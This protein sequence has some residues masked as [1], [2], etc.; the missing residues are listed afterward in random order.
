MLLPRT[1]FLVGFL[2]LVGTLRAEPPLHQ[3]IDALVVAGLPNYAEAAAPRCDD[4]EFL[5][6]VSLDL[7]GTIPPAGEVR[8]FLNDAAP[9]KRTKLVDRLLDS[10]EHARHFATVID[11][12]LME[13]RA[14][15]NVASADW[16]DYLRESVAANKPW[17]ALVREILSSDGADPKT[18][19]SGRFL[20]DRAGEPHLITRDIGRL[21]LGVNLQCAQCH[22]H[23]RVED[24]KQAHYYGI[25]A[26][27]GRTGLV[28]DP[29]LKLAVLTEKADGEATFQSVFDP[30]K[31]TMTGQPRL[32]GGKLVADAMVEKGKEYVIAPPAKGPGRAVPTYS[33]RVQ[34]APVLA[35]G[36]NIAFKRNIAN[37]LWAHLMGRGLVHPL[38]LDHGDNPPSHPELLDLLA[39]EVGHKFDLRSLLRE[40]ALSETYQ[41]AS[42]PTEKGKDVAA[43]RFVTAKLKPLTP[44]QLAFALMQATGFTDIQRTALGAKVTE[45][46]LHARIITGVGPF[47]VAFGTEP[48]TPESF[49]ARVEQALFLAN[50]PSLKSWLTP[51]GGNLTD[52]LLKAA[53][54]AF[55]EELYLSVY[56]RKPTPDEAKLIANFLARREDKPR[57]VQD[58]VW[59][60]LAT[61]EFRFNH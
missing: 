17:D 40:I 52:R 30:K 53:P 60:L 8:A 23:P 12:M 35:T 4:A 59:A 13:R 44:E 15:Q 43:D 2:S 19:P 10:P 38:D 37:R 50:G 36:D 57:A 7:I 58:L 56:T 11:V 6:R 24:Y 26:F 21:L 41:R 28:T 46:A 54:E 33:R 18:R 61:T 5:R 29:T 16:R 1:L 42:L 31:E 55:A 9:E 25:Y 49:D 45:D 47:V 32:P 51:G 14:T 27:L 34:L 20:L 48:G 22:D 3:R 39:E